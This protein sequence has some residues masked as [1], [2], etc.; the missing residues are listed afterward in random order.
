MADQKISVLV[1][2]AALMSKF[3][4]ILL[5]L[6]LFSC[7]VQERASITQD[8]AYVRQFHSGVRYML[9]DQ[10]DNA[11][12]DFNACLQKEPNDAAVHFALSQTYLKQENYNQAAFHTERAAALDPK[13]LHYKRELAFMYQQL[14]KAQEAAVVFEK[15]LLAEPKNI[16]YYS[17]ALMCYQ[18]LNKP[19]KSL[20]LIQKMELELGE[21][22]NTV[23]EKF[24]LLQQMGKTKES[25]TLLESARVQFPSDPNI[26]ANLVDNYF[27]AQNYTAGFEILDDLVQADPT[28]GVAQLMYGEMCYRSGK[29]DLGKKHL[30]LGILSEGPSIDQKMNVLIMWV[31]E[32]DLKD[33]NKQLENLVLY[34]TSAY[35][36]E[37][38]AHSIAG[39]YYY[40]I[41]QPKAA[42]DCYRQTLSIDPNLIA[43]WNQV[44]ILEYEQGLWSYLYQDATHCTEI[45]LNHVFPFYW[46][47]LTNN[48]LG[49]YQEALDALQ[50][51]S[52]LGIN[53]PAMKAE[54]NAQLGVA[55]FGLGQKEKGIEFFNAAIAA[56]P[57]NLNLKLD[58]LHQ[59]NKYQLDAKAHEALKTIVIEHPKEGWPMFELAYSF[60]QKGFY[61]DALEWQLKITD[62][63]I[64]ISSKYY[65]QLGDI[66]YQ[67]G[68]EIEALKSWQKALTFDEGSAVLNQKIT[69][70]K[71]VQAP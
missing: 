3:S 70:Q 2:T 62:P 37:A 17:G 41:G 55:Q 69:T 42:I 44:F 15:L 18:Q 16:D 48:Y 38:K 40:V 35:P 52:S 57:T 29:V 28:N 21:N 63:A 8:P 54:V 58:L 22:P 13:N 60:F 53:D 4:S 46:L 67:L 71:Y 65:E 34:M 36:K 33:A 27:R 23:I 10:H 31:N 45:Y 1:I 11:I 20:A 43:V 47:G 5:I 25:M 49:K 51:A 14:G 39:D 7:K 66:F 12:E 68:R 9:N 59:L 19:T 6:L 32:K 30:G 24:H 56:Q 61:L 26:L 64:L 50:W